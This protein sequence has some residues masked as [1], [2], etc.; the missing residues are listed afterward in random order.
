MINLIKKRLLLQLV[1]YF[2]IL[3][4]V[5]VLL[6]AIS[7]NV[8]SRDA[9]KRSVIDRLGVAT[10]LKEYQ[11][12]Q[13]VDN[14]RRDVI[15]MT[16]LQ[17]IISNAEIAFT[18]DKESPEFKAALE[19]IR[20]FM[21]DVSA[22]KP[23]IRQISVLTNNGITIVSTNKEKEGKYQPLGNTT[24][25]FTRDQSRVVVPNFY[26]SPI[27]GKA[28]M[29]F[30]APLSNKSGDRIGVVAVDLDL[31]GVDDIIRER[32]GLGNSGETYLV[33][34]LTSKNILISGKGAEDKDL[35]KGIKSD[36]INAA[37]KGEDGEGTYKNYK[38][39]PVLGNYVWI[40]N[41]N[42]ALIAEMSQVEAFEPADRLARDILL[43]GL[44]SAGILLTAVYLIARRISQPIL[45]IADAANQVSGGNL[46]SQA[47]VL[48]EDEIGILA[49][50]FNQ[51]TSQLRASGEQ[52]ADYSRTLEQKVE[53]R[54]SEIKAIID[55][56]VDGLVVVNGED[57]ITQFNPALAGM[58]GVS[59]KALSRAES[60]RDIFKAEEITN[61]VANTRENPK[62][63]FTEEFALPDR[64]TGKAVATSIFREAEGLDTS[65]LEMNYLGTVILIRDITAEKEVD[66]MKT[67][68]ISTVSHELR[69]PLTSVLGF[70]KL[71]QKKLDE[72]IFPMI[73]T[74][75]KKVNRSIRQVTENIEIIVS[76]G[77]RLTKLIN[78]VL[79]VAK[80]E[81][82]KMQWNME[83]LAITEVIDRAFSATS[84]LFEQK[85]LTPVR[86]IEAN[87]PNVSGDKD[88][89]I[90]VVINLISN[91]VKFTEQGSITCRVKQDGQSI[92]V[93]IIDQGV[94]ISESDQPK[95]FEK[96]K[97]VGDTLTDKPQGTGL[98]LPISKEI[99]AHH[100]GKIWL[101]SEIGKGSTFSFT[102]PI[103]IANEIP[104][105]NFD[106]LIEQLKK[107]EVSEGQ[108][109]PDGQTA[110]DAPKNILVID[111]DPSI[112]NLL[113]QELEAK[114]YT[115]REAG[116]GQEAIVQVRESRPDLITLD[117][118]M[119]GISGYDVAAILKSDPATL[120]IPIIIVSVLDDKN[121][122]RHLGIDSY[123]TKPLD[124]VILLREV[125][126]LLSSK[127]STGKKILVV[128]D[129]FGSID[130]LME[131]LHNQGFIPS[132]I[133]P[134]DNLRASAIADQ[135]DVI[136]ASTKLAEQV[137]SL[138][139]EQ[140]MEHIRFLLIAD[141]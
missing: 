110:I 133:N 98:G 134:Q 82:G 24:T 48:T 7:A 26:I 65:D 105:I 8:R 127:L 42:L 50:A 6:V 52:L 89:L 23:N 106:I 80:I 70:A 83:P 56:M 5:T 97:Q 64:R 13:W 88:R 36:G 3:S 73:Q 115:V 90:Q 33:G 93:S 78:E 28:A 95:V 135:P 74:D 59:S 29:T 99:V 4:I 40:D 87:L 75:D 66:R 85:A 100:G 51:M 92:M 121:K 84:A 131:M 81:A 132:K 11:V 43:I 17:D 76:E 45:A 31:Q 103:F 91:A 49:I 47:P 57:Q 138:R 113:R 107:R 120:D 37:A 104:L 46:D 139:A 41:L 102:L 129:N 79:D 27:S 111:D 58:I 1:G 25:Y 10:S 18:K 68:F 119:D 124:M 60:Y 38:N 21:S 30:A 61:L 14:Q 53:Q 62:Q 15:L 118:I 112:R 12:N 20:K 54:T 109:Q 44:S 34:R 101:E 114:G 9:L 94:G 125:D 117:I 137:Q 116:N 141:Q 71:I 122:G 63:V 130:L 126:I 77:T 108:A 55:N 22:V 39:I 67:D 19:S 86:E 32:T 96:F 136:I 128:D 72:S 2:S 35:A 16:Q 140:G 69:T 123:V